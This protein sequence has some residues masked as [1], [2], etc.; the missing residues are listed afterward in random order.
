MDNIKESIAVLP[1]P[2]S[3]SEDEQKGSLEKATVM[4][5]EGKL[6]QRLFDIGLAYEPTR[7]PPPSFSSF[8]VSENRADHTSLYAGLSEC[9]TEGSSSRPFLSL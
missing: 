7:E 3:Q 2:L 5:E 4:T 1:A 9:S 8:Q 6:N